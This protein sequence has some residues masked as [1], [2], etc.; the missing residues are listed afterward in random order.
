[1]HEAKNVA[2]FNE[3]YKRYIDFVTSSAGP[4]ADIE[5]IEKDA[6]EYLRTHTTYGELYK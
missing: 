3:A 4:S 5:Q 6:N 1:L 2:E